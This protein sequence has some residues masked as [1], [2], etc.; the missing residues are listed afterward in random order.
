MTV[1]DLMAKELNIEEQSN[2]IEPKPPRRR[3][4]SLK[5]PSEGR[6]AVQRISKAIKLKIAK[7]LQETDVISSEHNSTISR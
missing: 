5:S 6:E 4:Q 1:I 7:E 2:P 3:R